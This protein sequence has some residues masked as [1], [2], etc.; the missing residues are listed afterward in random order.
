MFGDRPLTVFL[1]GEE[2]H[3]AADSVQTGSC[4]TVDKSKRC[5]YVNPL[6]HPPVIFAPVASGSSSA[7]PPD[8]ATGGQ[9]PR[10]KEV[11]MVCIHVHRSPRHPR[12][13]YQQVVPH[14]PIDNPVP[15]TKFKTVTSHRA[16]IPR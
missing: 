12:R 1:A 13:S 4:C 15:V 7:H 16:D 14:K 9:P 6:V 3:S 2:T 11:V 10:L 5:I 8:P